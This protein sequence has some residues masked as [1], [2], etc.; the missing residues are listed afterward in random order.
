MDRIGKYEDLDK[1]YMELE[2]HSMGIA[3]EENKS[4]WKP[5]PF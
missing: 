5:M 1:K 4:L 3:K 2:S